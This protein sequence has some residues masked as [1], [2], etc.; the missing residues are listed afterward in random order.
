MLWPLTDHLGT[1]RDWVNNSA[2]IVDHVEYDSYGK[3]LDTP[4]IDAAFG[5]TG[6]YRDPLTGLQYNNRR[7]YDAT[8][9]RW[10]SEDFIWYCATNT[11]LS[12]TSR[13]CTF[14]RVT[15]AP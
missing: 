15:A 3:R 6:R 1:V 13:R 5:W 2:V 12:A 4:A 9:G 10:L 14:I 7:W 11:L 8:N